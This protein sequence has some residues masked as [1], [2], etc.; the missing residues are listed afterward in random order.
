MLDSFRPLSFFQRVLRLSQGEPST[1]AV[2][3]RAGLLV[4]L[5]ALPLCLGIAMASGFPPIAGIITAAI[6]GIVATW[7]GSAPLT[8]K[9]PAAGLIV[10]ALGAV[11]ELGAGD[12]AT[13]YR[14]ALAVG[15][16]AALLQIA[17]G[18]LRLASAGVAMSP[19]IVHG[20]LAA[21]GVI[22]MSK[23]LH[24][25]AGVKP[26]G[27]EPLE[28]LVEL[29][30]SLLAANPEVLLI[31]TGSLLLLFLHR[32]LPWRWLR[33]VPGQALVLVFAIPLGLYF[34][35]DHAHDYQALSHVYHLGPE[36][37]VEL[38]S[39]PLDALAFPDF[40]IIGSAAS[41]KY[42][43]MF[44]LVG[45]IES[46]LSTLAVDAL[47]PKKRASD[48]NKD[49]FATGVGNFLAALVGGLPMI[50]EIVRS[51]ANID[52]GASSKK[53]NFCHGIFLTVAVALIPTLLHQIPLAALAAMLVF[54][55][56]RLASPREFVHV[57]KIGTDQL[58]LFVV[59][60]VTTLVTDL[61]IGVAAG[62]VLEVAF[63]LFRG[64]SLRDIFRTRVEV[65]RE[66]DR[67]TLEVRGEAAFGGV[68]SVRKALEDVPAEVKFVCVDLTAV[69]L[70]D[71]TF[72]AR[73]QAMSDEWVNA[74]LE[75]LGLDGMRAA[76][77]HPNATRR[78]VA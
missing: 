54:T 36:Y 50:S 34:D 76:S 19:S 43:L 42:I 1:W 39:S 22:I 11:T 37:L 26:L 16:V 53:A 28:L 7:L 69:R 48:L 12:A 49:L 4:S 15:V 78:R 68:L 5:I 33:A 65:R 51:K 72:L 20:M 8:I 32:F 67:L 2:D 47:D 27:H 74:E 63:H 59:T 6:G 55:G 40:S 23:Q 75:I 71:H 38:P 18:A 17:M 44:A 46:V 56:S 35:M 14:R 21:I 60:L 57:R 64:A 9:G 29:P 58:V 24:T 41:L 77:E 3:A 66:Q 10:I 30:Q 52:A 62:F 31:G 70:V 61:L 73:L 25:V 13:G 45:S